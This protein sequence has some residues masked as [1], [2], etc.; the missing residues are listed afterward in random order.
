M[1]RRLTAA[2]ILLCV[3]FLL[4]SCAG[5]PGKN[6]KGAAA[7]SKQAGAYIVM[8][9]VLADA[10]GRPRTTMKI[11]IPDAAGKQAVADALSSALDFARKQDPALKAAIIW[12]YRNRDEINGSSYTL[13]KLEWTSDGMNYNGDSKLDPNP[14]IETTAL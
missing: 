12:A 5:K 6:E 1:M 3:C 14:K 9:K 2:F 7:P 4:V 10:P 8:E 13:G 11:I